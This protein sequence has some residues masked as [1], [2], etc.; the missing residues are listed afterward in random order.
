MSGIRW[1]QEEY[2][3][4]LKQSLTPGEFIKTRREQ[5]NPAYNRATV[6]VA[7]VESAH[8]HPSKAKNTN[9]GVY[10]LV[11]I[12]V[13]SKRRRLA[14]P[15]GISAKAAID[16]LRAGGLLIDD[17]ARYVQ[18]VSFSQEKSNV[19]ETIITMEVLNR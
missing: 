9:H 18:E 17:S 14:D 10:T 15:D 6:Q 7:H 5:T 16:G 19:E 12:H 2:E 11:R 4:W 3:Q 8:V 1:T 13:H